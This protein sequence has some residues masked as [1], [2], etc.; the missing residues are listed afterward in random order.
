VPV[1]DRIAFR[2]AVRAAAVQLLRD[3]GAEANV[4]LTVYPARPA[5]VR[6]PHA[7]VDTVRE[8]IPRD[9]YLGPHAIQR[10]P[11]AEVVVLW[12]LF[13]SA[14]AVTQADQFADEFLVWVLE[15]P[16]AAG[17]RT[18]IGVTAIEDEPTFVPDWLAPEYQKTYFATRISLEGHATS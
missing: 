14:E 5:S 4:K 10:F 15:R 3:Y 2:T 7:F 11:V 16:Y 12:G 17:A 1:L 18:T 8:S 9:Q 13:D 6:P